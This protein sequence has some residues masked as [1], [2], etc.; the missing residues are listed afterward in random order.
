M[1]RAG[2]S[3]VSLCSYL[4]CPPEQWKMS[5]ASLGQSSLA[6]T[7]VYLRRHEGQED[8]AWA[9]VAAAIGV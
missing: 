8:C 6:V 1:P 3:M 9:G 7:T 4:Q 2:E 5:A